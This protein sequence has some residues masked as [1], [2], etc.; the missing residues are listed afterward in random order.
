MS[1]KCSSCGENIEID[2]LGKFS[3]TIKKIKSDE[4]NEKAYFCSSCQKT[5]KDKI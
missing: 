2:E 5:G 3:G 4:K 1:E